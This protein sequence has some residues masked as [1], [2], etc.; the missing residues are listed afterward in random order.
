MGKCPKRRSMN[1]VEITDIRRILF[2]EAPYEFTIEVIIRILFVYILLVVAMRLLGTRIAARI[3]R[4][5]LIGLVT[6]SAGVGMAILN[7]ERGLLPPVVVVIVVVSIQYFIARITRKSKTADRV[8]LDTLTLLVK[9]GKFE[10]KAMKKTRI[11]K[12]RMSAELRANSIKNLGIVERAYMEANGK[13]TVVTFMDNKERQ[14]LCLI[15]RFDKEFRQEL[16]N[17]MEVTLACS[18]CGNVEEKEKVRHD[19]ECS[20]CGNKSWERAI[21]GE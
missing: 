20:N 5:E 7:P 2:G 6:L 11:T 1:D 4:N 10:L 17:R 21:E 19:T 8:I 9:D 12:E 3:T 16:N 13:F 14:G 18:C 15:P